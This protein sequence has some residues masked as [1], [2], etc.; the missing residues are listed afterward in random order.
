MEEA[1]LCRRFAPR[2]RLYGLKHLRTEDRAADLVQHV[3][4][5]AIEALRAD[6]VEDP[7][8]LDR[9]ILGICRNTAHRLRDR[10]ARLE[11]RPDHELDT[12]VEMNV[13]RL[14][15]EALYRCL[16]AL[17]ERSRAVVR[18]TFEE[19]HSADE[20]ATR[21]AISAANVRVLRH[22]AIAGLRECIDRKSSS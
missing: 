10:D 18:M 16:A 21:L 3:L 4:T 9:F 6:R 15:I 22:R 13:E 11:P 12:P 19:E 5:A 7:S 17:E 20:I 14:D 1:E 2:I 8:R